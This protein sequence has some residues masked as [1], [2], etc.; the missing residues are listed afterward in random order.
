MSDLFPITLQEMIEEVA[1]EGIKRR[2]VYPRLV[3]EKK[4]NRRMADRRIDIIDA[5]LEH[6]KA[7]R[8][9]GR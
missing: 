3:A 4:L 2:Q 7:E 9:A 8:D 6:L 1:R 5:L